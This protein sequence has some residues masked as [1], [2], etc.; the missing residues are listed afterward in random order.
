MMPA[1]LQIR[2]FVLVSQD[3]EGCCFTLLDL[4]T[5][6]KNFGNWQMLEAAVGRGSRVRSQDG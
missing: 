2:R 6:V 4:H 3:S 5:W 1:D